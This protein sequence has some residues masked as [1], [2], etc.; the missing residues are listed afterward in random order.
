MVCG[1]TR[2]L[3]YSLVDPGVVLHGARAQ[4]IHSGIDPVVP[5]GKPREVSQDFQFRH[6]GETVDL[7]ADEVLAENLFGSEGGNVQRRKLDP[8]LSG[9]RALED[10]ALVSS[11]VGSSVLDAIFHHRTGYR[12]RFLRLTLFPTAGF[13]SV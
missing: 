5:G 12:R 13:S 4:R 1:G 3:G 7:G 10:Q 6:F 8:G 11:D 9:R 2:E